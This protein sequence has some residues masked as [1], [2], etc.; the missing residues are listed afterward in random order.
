MALLI[1][2]SGCSGY[3]V[4]CS[5]LEDYSPDR[6]NEFT[7]GCDLAPGDEVRVILVNKEMVTGVIDSVLPTEIALI[8]P[9]GDSVPLVIPGERVDRVEEKSG[10][11]GRTVI[12]VAV[13]GTLAAALYVGASNWSMY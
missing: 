7:S 11:P 6:N 4:S 10:S 13:I 2:V 3:C 8:V 5:S 12:G 9:S 1:L